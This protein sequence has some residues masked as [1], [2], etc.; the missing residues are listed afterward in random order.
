MQPVVVKYL[1]MLAPAD[2]RKP[3]LDNPG[4]TV[5]EAQENFPVVNKAFYERVGKPWK[6]FDKLSWTDQQ[7][8]NYV[9]RDNL[10]TFV[11]YLRT[12]SIGYFELELQPERNVQILYFGLIPEFLGKGLGS[13]FLSAAIDAAW[14]F[15]TNR[16]WLHT[17]SFDHPAALDN[18]LN[19]GFK[20]FKIE[21]RS[22]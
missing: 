10:K 19:R 1:E 4:I 3:K 7:W 14:S 15:S 9:C 17:C 21:T 8:T 11:G 18:Y 5:T 22:A 16:V 20:V 2:H 6:W 12:T 13:V